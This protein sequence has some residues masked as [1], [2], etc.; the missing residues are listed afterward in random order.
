[1]ALEPRPWFPN[2]NKGC[3]MTVALA[4]SSPGAIR[5]CQ[6][7]H[8][9]CPVIELS[10]AA[11][12]KE[13]HHISRKIPRDAIYR[14]L[15]HC[16]GGP[17]LCI[18]TFYFGRGDSKGDRLPYSTVVTLTNV[19][20]PRQ[21]THVFPLHPLHDRR[22]PMNGAPDRARGLSWKLEG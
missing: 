20:R 21:P 1:M 7:Q 17:W 14:E 3:H 5:E 4:R 10:T 12:R 13:G 18:C 15:R 2:E 19:L 6:V 8:T 16:L 11:P 9:A 22:D